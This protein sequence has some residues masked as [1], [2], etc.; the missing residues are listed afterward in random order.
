LFKDAS[1]SAQTELYDDYEWSSPGT[2]KTTK[3]SDKI[4]GTRADIR[5]M[6]LESVNH[7]NLIIH[8]DCEWEKWM[9]S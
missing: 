9:K 1:S 8:E 7:P 4:D 3:N 2:R 5:T 6:D